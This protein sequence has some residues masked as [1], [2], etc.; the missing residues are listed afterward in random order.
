MILSRD[1][2]F[3]EQEELRTAADSP[4]GRRDAPLWT[5]DFASLYS[6]MK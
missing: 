3:L 5:D 4:A 2:T 1:K 6:I